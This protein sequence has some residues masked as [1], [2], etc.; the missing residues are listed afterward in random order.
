MPKGLD[1]TSNCGAKAGEIRTAGYDFVARYLSRDS[2]KVISPDESKQLSSAGL[3]I[4]LI[5]E[6]S[7][8]SVSY[9]SDS[10]GHSDGAR[11]AEQ[12]AAIGGNSG[13]TIYFA[14]DYN[15]EDQ[16]ITGA[17]TNYFHGV[18]TSLRTFATELGTFFRIGVYG[19]G[20]RSLPQDWLSRGGLPNRWGGAAMTILQIGPS[21]KQTQRPCLDFRLTQ[22]TP[23]VIT[24]R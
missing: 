20:A 14:V 12:A 4:V 24:G 5:Y 19:S 1:T 22:M 7:P 2:W 8:T 23:F 10:R 15:A 17:I 3:A 9:F 21:S 13:T 11:A 6:D 18:A 16:E